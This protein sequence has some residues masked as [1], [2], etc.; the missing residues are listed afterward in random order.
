MDQVLGIR[1]DAVLGSEQRRE[2]EGVTRQSFNP[3]GAG[4]VM[5]AMLQEAGVVALYGTSFVDAVVEP[6]SGND[7]ITAIIVENASGRQA[8]TGKIFIEGSGTAQLA[9]C[10]GVP[11]ILGWRSATR[12]PP[13]GTAATVRFPAACCGS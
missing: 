2:L 7:S 13:S 3:E 5:A 9:A 6:G 4:S 8:I 12:R 1:P 10:A 11:F